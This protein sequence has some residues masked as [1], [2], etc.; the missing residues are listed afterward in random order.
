MG[1][2][3]FIDRKC[4]IFLFKMDYFSRK[5]MIR[6]RFTFFFFYL[7]F[8]IQIKLLSHLCSALIN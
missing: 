4:V 1:T 7:T 3:R 6:V 5:N 2:T 8:L